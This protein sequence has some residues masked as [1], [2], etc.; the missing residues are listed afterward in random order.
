MKN[1]NPKPKYK[2]GEKVKIENI[3][4]EY[5]VLSSKNN[6]DGKV[7]YDLLP[8]YFLKC[9]DVR[10]DY[11]T[12]IDSL[13]SHQINVEDILEITVQKINPSN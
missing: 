13:T 11:I 1:N 8:F 3:S 9:E 10:E 4:E 7:I 6:L 5:V 12:G 2:V